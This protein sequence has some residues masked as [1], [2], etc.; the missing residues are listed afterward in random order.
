V[1][2]AELDLELAGQHFTLLQEKEVYYKKQTSLEP[3]VQF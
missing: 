2:K 1:Q 3:L